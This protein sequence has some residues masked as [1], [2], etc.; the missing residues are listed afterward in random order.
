MKSNHENPREGDLLRLLSDVLTTKVFTYFGFK[1]RLRLDRLCM[2]WQIENQRKSLPLYVPEDCPT[3]EEAVQRVEQDQRITT[4]VLGQGEHQI[5]V[6][7]KIFSAMSIVGRP[8]VLKEKIVV[9]GG[10]WFK[11]EIQGNCHLQH[12]TIRQAKGSGVWGGSS[13][14]MEDVI[15][16]QCGWYGVVADG[17]GIVGRCTNVEVR[18]CE[19]SGMVAMQGASITLI[20]AKTTVHDNCTEERSQNYGL[21]V[22]GSSSSTIQLVYP[23]TK[24]QV[25]IKNGR[26]GNWGAEFGG[27]INQIKTIKKSSVAFCVAFSRDMLRLLPD[28]V[29]TTKVFTYFNFKDYALTSCVSEYLQAHWQTANQ[30]NPLPLYVPEDCRTLQRAVGTVAYDPRITTIVL[31]KGEHQ[32]EDHHLIIF[33]AMSIVGRPD[34]PKEKIVVVGGGMHFRN[35]GQLNYGNY[36]LQHMTI[37]QA[38]GNGVRVDSHYASHYG[39]YSVPAEDVISF[40]ME[41][42]IVEQCGECGVFA[43]GTGVVGRCT[44]VEVRQCGMSGVVADNDGSITL[45]GAQT[46]V[47]HN[48]TAGDSHEYGL[49]VTCWSSSSTIQLVCPL[50]KEQISINNGGGGNWG[51]PYGGDINQIKTIDEPATGETKSNH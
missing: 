32:I 31:G 1:E 24:E 37:R 39:R 23:L 4:I 26:G 29:L 16:E 36:H 28:P 22:S 42:V 41:D 17:T 27:H 12:M 14:T 2:H 5:G 35:E 46:T 48:C 51:A 33:S 20:G 6:S 45:I 25:A 7:L 50:T 8:G 38:E 9:M 21:Q 19:M 49:K 10:I 34:V 44:N 30:I 11:R 40:T 47:H 18:Q 43:N 3:L 15:V 13:F